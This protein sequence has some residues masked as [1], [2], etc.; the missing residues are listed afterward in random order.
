MIYLIHGT[1]QVDSRRFLV[2]LK[3][4]YEDIQNIPGKNLN[5]K[6]LEEKLKMANQYLFGG[7]SAFLIENFS[8]D[9]SVFPKNLPESLDLILWASEKIEV[10]NKKVKSFLFD[11]KKKANA[12]RLTDAILFRDEKE[13]FAT[14][15]QLLLEK[16]PT[17]KIVG[18]ILRGLLLAFCAKENLSELPLAPF[19]RQKVE[20]QAKFWSK[21][22][23]KRAILELLRADLDL[24]SG[25][26]SSLVFSQLIG[27][28]IYS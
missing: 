4:D 18:A 14:A 26:S 22:G 3:T 17:E 10:G 2:R 20:D 15:T 12:F 23:L 11:Q 19:A 16:E 6:V 1:N 28:L 5:K 13:A 9:W 7:K 24:K 27:R 8:G 21:S 25:K